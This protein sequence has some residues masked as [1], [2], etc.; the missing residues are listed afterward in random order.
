MRRFYLA[1]VKKENEFEIEE[2]EDIKQENID[3]G[4]ILGVDEFKEE[5]ARPAQMNPAKRLVMKIPD[6][7]DV[8][9]M[10]SDYDIKNALS[11]F[12]QMAM[13]FAIHLYGRHG[14]L[15]PELSCA[16]EKPP[17]QQVDIFDSRK[18]CENPKF[19]L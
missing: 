15:M 2:E 1:S 16:E 11:E 17:H 18:N 6:H 5:T 9:Q 8:N 14:V 10:H 19:H 7:I 12:R 4:E 3:Y 13:L